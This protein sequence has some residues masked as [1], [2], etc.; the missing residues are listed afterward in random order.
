M[1]L[2]EEDRRCSSLDDVCVLG[3]MYIH[4]KQKWTKR[5]RIPKVRLTDSVVDVF[6]AVPR[7]LPTECPQG[8]FSNEVLEVPVPVEERMKTQIEVCVESS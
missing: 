6:V 2:E 5:S 3:Q 4:T 8:H 1:I 7:Q